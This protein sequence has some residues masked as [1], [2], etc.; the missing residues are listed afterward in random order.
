V[1][2]DEHAEASAAVDVA[3][4]PTEG[5]TPL[6]DEPWSEAPAGSVPATRGRLRTA[7]PWVLVVLAVAVAVVSTWRWQELAAVDRT[8]AD[9]ATATSQFVAILT[10]WDATEGMATTRDQLRERGSETFARDVDELFGSTEDLRGLA[11]LGAR[12]EG[13]VRDVFVQSVAGDHAEALAVVLQQVTT[14]AVPLPEVHLRYASVTL[15]RVDGRWLVD[16]LELL[17]D[18]SPTAG[19]SAPAGGAPTDGADDAAGEP[20]TDAQEDGS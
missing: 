13:D 10:T 5:D 7:L 16:D 20:A 4:D 3:D 14:D 11:E 2:S 12:S 18:T 17:I 9:V 19:R 8:R 1:V 15:Q 6:V